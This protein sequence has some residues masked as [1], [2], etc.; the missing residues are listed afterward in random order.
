MGRFHNICHKT[1]KLFSKTKL[2]LFFNKAPVPLSLW[3]QNKFWYKLIKFKKVSLFTLTGRREI[4]SSSLHYKKRHCVRTRSCPEL[5]GF[6]I[7]L[8]FFLVSGSR[9]KTVI[10]NNNNKNTCKFV[11]AIPSLCTIASFQLKPFSNMSDVK[12]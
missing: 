2:Y 12:M 7:T 10:N 1:A 5:T 4:R 9:R 6:Y 8:L 3:W 11:S